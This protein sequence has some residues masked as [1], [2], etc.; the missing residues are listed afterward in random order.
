MKKRGLALWLVLAM[1]LTMVPAFA[2]ESVDDEKDPE[3]A[4]VIRFAV[5]DS[6]LSINGEDVTVETPYVVDGATLVPVRVITEAFGAEVDWD[7]TTKT[8]IVSYG[9]ATIR[10]TIGSLTAD[11]NGRKET[12]LAAPELTNDVTM[13]PLRFITEAFG[14]DVSYDNGKIKVIKEQTESNS[15]KDYAMILKR[16]AKERVGDSYYTW[17][18]DRPSEFK[19]IRRSFDGFNNLFESSSREIAIS[20]EL[21]M[22]G[23]DMTIDD[24]LQ[25]LRKM[26]QKYTVMRLEKKS[27]AGGTQYVMAQYQDSEYYFDDRVYIADDLLYVV[28]TAVTQ[29]EGK[30][31]FDEA[32][33]IADSFEKSFKAD[34]AEDLSDVDMENGMRMFDNKDL[35]IK[36]LIPG[37]LWEDTL[38]SASNRFR[39]YHTNAE[40]NVDGGISIGVYSNEPNSTYADWCRT[41]YEHNRRALNPSMATFTAPYEL[42]VDGKPAMAYDCTVTLDKV[43]NY[44]KD[45]FI[46]AGDYFYNVHVSLDKNGNYEEM[47]K[48]IVASVEIGT[49]DSAEVGRLIRTDITEDEPTKQHKHESAKYSLEAPISWE[50]KT[51]NDGGM[52]LFSEDDVCSLIVARAPRSDMRGTLKELAAS[53]YQDKKKNENATMLSEDVQSSRVGGIS[54]YRVMIEHKEGAD[55]EWVYDVYFF[56]SG[57]YIYQIT[58]QT[59]KL[60]RGEAIQETIDRILASFKIQK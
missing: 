28:S 45:I 49:I 50:S 43:S 60:G 59:T 25:D 42:T 47:M 57:D 41:D 58:V 39:F 4:I 8:A 24:Y 37:N 19:L 53:F 44:E 3:H 10:L 6:T 9:E 33:T 21:M 31:A 18:M 46:D 5:G 2:A 27:T 38:E 12:L 20:V 48:T 7:N 32:V 1:L 40:G 52:L 34:V 30:R 36:M 51:S 26:T 22:P 13:L 14:A 55:L 56:Q 35:H 15:I 11:I 29:K 23:D 16:S 17:S 54:A